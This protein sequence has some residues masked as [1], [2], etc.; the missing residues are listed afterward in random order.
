MRTP[1]SSS[2]T[3][4]TSPVSCRCGS[5]REAM[6][7]NE[8]DNR[9][10]D[11]RVVQHCEAEPAVLWIDD[12]TGKIVDCSSPPKSRPAVD[13]FWPKAGM[14]SRQR[15]REASRVFVDLVGTASP[16]TIE[17]SGP[18][19]RMRLPLRVVRLLPARGGG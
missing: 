17:D 4:R 10:E 14:R 1:R 6:K 9:I 15:L 5:D 19:K 2:M 3:G 11:S 18:L 7:M 12:A 8:T 13:E 16:M